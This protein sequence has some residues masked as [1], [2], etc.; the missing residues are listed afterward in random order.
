VASI[1]E[2]GIEVPPVECGPETYDMLLALVEAHKRDEE[3]EEFRESMCN[4]K[5]SITFLGIIVVRCD[6]VPEGRFWPARQI[7]SIATQRKL[8]ADAQ[9]D[10][11]TAW[12]H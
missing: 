3:V 4:E 6:D 1:R 7:S 2:N 8:E 9:F 5:S 10:K 11:V 12:P